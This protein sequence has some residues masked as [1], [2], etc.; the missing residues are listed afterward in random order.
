MNTAAKPRRIGQYEVNERLGEGGIGQVHAARDVELDREVALK[1]LRPELLNDANFVQRFRAEA[2]N[3]ARLNHHNITTLYSLMSQ[4]KN[5]Y[6]VMELVRGHTLEELLQQRGGP[7]G[8]AES[9]GIIQQAGEGLAYAHRMGII[10]RDI[11]PSNIMI[12]EA[13]V[14]KLMDFGIARVQGSQRLTRAGSI[15]GTLAYMAPEQLK[16]EEGDERSDLY[17]LAIV[18]YEM[19]TGHVPFSGATDYELMQAQ[20]NQQPQRP[21][22]RLPNALEPRVEDALM[23]ALDKDPANRFPTVA[24]FLDALGATTARHQAITLVQGG[25]RLLNQATTGPRSSASDAASPL[26]KPAA[27]AKVINEKLQNL[28]P[29]W[30][31]AVIGGGGALAVV[32]AIA[33]IMTLTQPTPVDNGKRNP[34]NKNDGASQSGQQTFSQPQTVGQND[35]PS[36]QN[37]RRDSTT[38]NS[39]FIPSPNSVSANP[40]QNT[41]KQPP[42]EQTPAPTPE[43]AQLLRAAY[44]GRDYNRART[45]AFQLCTTTGQRGEPCYLLGR[46]FEEGRGGLQDDAQAVNY[47]RIAA[48]TG[49]AK[50]MERLGTMYFEGRGGLPGDKGEAIRWFRKSAQNGTPLAMFKLG[51]IY[52]NGDGTDRDLNQAVFWLNRARDF[53]ETRDLATR[54]LGQLPH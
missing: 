45:L 16:G 17:S 33:T 26:L 38:R 22:E 40:Q 27:S 49:D 25:T 36:A 11:K 37:I 2:T 9:L 14:V 6:M 29:S 10:H 1:S 51:S 30:R 50:A 39:T 48:D 41:A 44:S 21:S 53:P 32:A 34:V 5:L 13:G 19:L 35:N 15:V 54:T 8:M 4:G 43:P 3:L 20:I 23:Q 24:D 12:T 7:L 46:M 18:L 52:M 31:G 42:V 47:Y 28:P